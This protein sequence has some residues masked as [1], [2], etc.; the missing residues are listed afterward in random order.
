VLQVGFKMMST[1]TDQAAGAKWGGQTQ[2]PLA[3]RDLEMR[4]CAPSAC[5]VSLNNVTLYYI[6]IYIYIYRIERERE[7]ERE[8]DHYTY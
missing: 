1:D 4:L 6:Y 7:R 3:T 8:R 2:E 5:H